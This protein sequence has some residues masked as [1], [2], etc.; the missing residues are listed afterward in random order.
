MKYLFFG[1][2][3]VGWV[4]FRSGTVFGSIA[5]KCF[6]VE[7]SFVAVHIPQTFS[8]VF[9]MYTLV[10]TVFM[11]EVVI[12]VCATFVHIIYTFVSHR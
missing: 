3:I 7:V 11:Q 8:L 6:L 4:W 10:F 2:L 9:T 1:S 12:S 5:L